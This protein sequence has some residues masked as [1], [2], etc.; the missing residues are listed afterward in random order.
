METTLSQ[1][2]IA[3]LLGESLT[4]VVL[5]VAYIFAYIGIF[6][7]WFWMYQTKGKIDPTTPVKFNLNYWLRD[8]L[9]PKLFSVMATFLLIFISLR[10]AQEL[11][12]NVF[13]YWYALGV[14]LGLDYFASLLKKLSKTV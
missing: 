3:Q 9:L 5:L 14:G 1:Q 13:S 2:I 8:N 6:F 11:I 4:P 7:R 12:G 10:F